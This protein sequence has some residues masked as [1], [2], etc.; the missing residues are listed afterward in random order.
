MRHPTIRSDISIRSSRDI[1]IDIQV[2]VC[3]QDDIV[4]SALTSRIL[5]TKSPDNISTYKTELRKFVETNNV[6]KNTNNIHTK[7]KN[8]ILQP[9]AMIMINKL[10][11]TITKGMFQV[12]NKIIKTRFTHPWS[13]TL[14]VAILTL[15]L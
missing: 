14:A 10:D 1:Y 12:K 2:K 8:N 9:T 5:S 15:S 3:L 13:P 11:A 4:S 7:M 6:V